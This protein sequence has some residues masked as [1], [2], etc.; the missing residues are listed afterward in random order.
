MVVTIGRKA[1]AWAVALCMP[2]LLA[3]CSI[4]T[5]VETLLRPPNP[6]GEQKKIQ[7]VLEQYLANREPDENPALSGNYVLKYPHSGEY[8]SAFIL[9]DMNSDGSD[10]AIVCYRV[11]S[12]SS[13]VRLNLVKKVGNV[14]KSVSDVEGASTDLEQI[15][16]G[17]LDGDG[18]LE[19]FTGWNIDN[20]RDRQMVLY[21]IRDGEFSEWYQELYSQMVVS[22]LTNS[23]RDNLLLF[24]AQS[25]D[26]TTVARL[27]RGEIDK[28]SNLPVLSEL[29]S[30]RLDGYIQQF[31][32][33]HITKLSDSQVGVFVDGT[34][35]TEGMVTELVYWDGVQLKAPFYSAENN[36]TDLTYR[37][38]ALASRDVDGDG[39]IEWPATSAPTAYAKD[40]QLSDN[41]IWMATWRSWNLTSQSFSDEFTSLVNLTDRYVLRLDE[42]WAAAFSVSYDKASRVLTIYSTQV[43]TQPPVLKLWADYSLGLTGATSAGNMAESDTTSSSPYA[44]TLLEERTDVHYHLWYSSLA[45][46]KPFSLD[47]ERIRYLFI[48]IG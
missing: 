20:V 41:K 27:F 30:A 43:Q 17:D 38:A 39:M 10:E 28:V 33:P 5:N 14:W 42:A 44:F 25:G 35:S 13:N 4:G 16:F 45:E 48:S 9:Q 32:T 19:L 46:E 24:R 36:T 31:S 40:S 6:I 1:A 47:R 15:S 8:R 23:G 2:L 37:S 12:E 26:H 7:Q 11:G 34:R 21:S 29:G 22:D 3:G 18:T